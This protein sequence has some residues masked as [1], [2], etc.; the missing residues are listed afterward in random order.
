[1]LRFSVGSRCAIDSLCDNFAEQVQHVVRLIFLLRQLIFSTL[2]AQVSQEGIWHCKYTLLLSVIS[3]ILSVIEG[4]RNAIKSTPFYLLLDQYPLSLT[5]L[6]SQLYV[7]WCPLL[8]VS[9]SQLWLQEAVPKICWSYLNKHLIYE[10]DPLAICLW[11]QNNDQVENAYNVHIGFVN[12]QHLFCTHCKATLFRFI[13][14]MMATEKDLFFGHVDTESI[15]FIFFFPFCQLFFQIFERV[16]V[17]T[18]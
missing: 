8:P 17:S 2:I 14:K 15:C 12:Y 3:L 7:T 11:Y 1:M 6:Y 4:D 10:I 9:D 13:I 16:T 18:K 5:D